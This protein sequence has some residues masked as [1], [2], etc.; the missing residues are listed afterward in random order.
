MVTRRQ[1]LECVSDPDDPAFVKPSLNMTS[2]PQASGIV[3]VRPIRR[4][5][6]CAHENGVSVLEDSDEDET[7]SGTVRYRVVSVISSI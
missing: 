5:G 4:P 7:A 2:A 3:A 6:T 1:S